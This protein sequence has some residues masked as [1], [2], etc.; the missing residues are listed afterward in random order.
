M[1]EYPFPELACGFE[2][3]L[4]ALRMAWRWNKKRLVGS[5]ENELMQTCKALSDL[6]I[7]TKVTATLS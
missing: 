3:V 1:G 6:E 7:L 5:M 4:T 2:K